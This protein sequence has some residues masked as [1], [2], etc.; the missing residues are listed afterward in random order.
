M[1]A[2]TPTHPLDDLDCVAFISIKLHSN[3]A[4]SISG[5]VGDKRLALQLIAA[6]RDAINN[7]VK[8]RNAIIIPNRDVDVEQSPAFPTLPRG[9]MKPEDR[10]DVP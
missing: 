3:S 2:P 6:A 1:G 8:E 5:N 10:G 9:D 7:Q 4:V